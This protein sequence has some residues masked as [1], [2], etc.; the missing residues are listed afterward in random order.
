MLVLAIALSAQVPAAT[1]PQV[2]SGPDIVITGRSFEET[3]RKL[4]EC[5]ARKCPIEE[6]VRATLAHAENLYVAGEYKTARGTLLASIGRNKGAAKAHPAA[7]SDLYRTNGRVATV[8][9]EKQDA[10]TSQI[11]SL[12]ALRA[13][14]EP[15][16]RRVFVQRIEVADTLAKQGRL[17]AALQ[18]YGKVAGD[19]DRAGV[20]D[21]VGYA[22]LRTATLLSAISYY[23]PEY[24]ARADQ[25]LAWFDAQQAPGL[26]PF[27]E[28]AH[29]I[30]ARAAIRAGD[31]SALKRLVAQSARTTTPKLLYAPV[32]DRPIETRGEGQ[33]AVPV[34]SELNRLAVA[35]DKEQWVD[36]SFW[37][38]PDGRVG[39]AEILRNGKPLD[40]DW[41]KPI[42]TALNGRIYA[43]LT[44]PATNPGV[45]RVERYTRF[46]DL[47]VNTG[48][49]LR[50]R[51]PRTRIEMLDLSTGG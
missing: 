16:D 12:E 45:L 14:V 26:A 50:V 31:E 34:A 3:A 27:R 29:V 44:M 30:S 7:V 11:S 21:I 15:T 46:A 23:E 33:G 35:P 48:S 18:H 4:E 9:G 13:G 19:A 37:V 20:T 39:D 25:A 36:I 40:E 5:I 24:K 22:R 8:L 38:R 43:P 2:A 49:R 42:L 51:E 1:A 6:D 10:L 32:I 17:L 28:A 41:V 47:T